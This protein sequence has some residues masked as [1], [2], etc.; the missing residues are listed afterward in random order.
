M[1][2]VIAVEVLVEAGSVEEL[3]ALADEIESAAAAS[4]QGR[5]SRDRAESSSVCIEAR[6]RRLAG[7]LGQRGSLGGG[8]RHPRSRVTS[9]VSTSSR[10]R[11]RKRSVEPGRGGSDAGLPD[12]VGEVPSHAAATARRTARWPPP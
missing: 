9:R 10:A 6:E 3:D 5:L 12:L 2:F 7:G 1:R 11:G 4:A 8:K